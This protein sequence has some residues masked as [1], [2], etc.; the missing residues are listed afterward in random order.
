MST[1]GL[2]PIDPTFEPAS[3]R[4]GSP[5]VQKAYASALDFESMLVQQLSQ[6]LTQ[7]SGL[8]GEGEAGAQAGGEGQGGGAGGDP[9]TAQ[10]S[11][12]LPQTLTTSV[13]S[14]GGLGM[15]QQLMGTL[16]PPPA[17]KVGSTGGVKA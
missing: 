1:A 6:S 9:I 11:S 15:A 17:S 5:A 8:G 7:T 14:H 13:M 2:P 10:L 3:V 12:L 4:G 16:L